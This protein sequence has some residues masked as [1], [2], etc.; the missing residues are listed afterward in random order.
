MTL[1]ETLQ[2]KEPEWPDLK[3]YC[4]FFIDLSNEYQFNPELFDENAKA[5]NS[6]LPVPNPAN[7]KFDPPLVSHLKYIVYEGRMLIFTSWLQHARAF[8]IFMSDENSRFIGGRFNR[9]KLLSAGHIDIDFYSDGII[10][11]VI[12]G[13]SETLSHLLA[14]KKSER[15]K[16]STLRK[17]LGDFFEIK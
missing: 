14:V 1:V 15:Y 7:S 16:H 12:S 9:R 5:V 6:T 11:R 10:Q 13:E 17:K 2:T 8:G 4:Y 3:D